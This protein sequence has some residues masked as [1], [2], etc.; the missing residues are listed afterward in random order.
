MP[1]NPPQTQQRMAPLREV[2]L[3]LLLQHQ[4]AC[5]GLRLSAVRPPYP[6]EQLPESLTAHPT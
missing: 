6:H 3:G 5:P 4:T 1:T 2:I